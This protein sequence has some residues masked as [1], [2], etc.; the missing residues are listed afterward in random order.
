MFRIL[1]VFIGLIYVVV[2]LSTL[3]IALFFLL[4][5]NVFTIPLFLLALLGCKVTT[6]RLPRARLYGTMLYPSWRETAG[7]TFRGTVDKITT[8]SIARGNAKMRRKWWYY[9]PWEAR[10]FW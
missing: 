10:F 5:M 3:M 4:C 1:K 7:F 8:K 2:Y 9:P 6:T